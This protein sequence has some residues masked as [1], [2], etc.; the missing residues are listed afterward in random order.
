MRSCWY[1]QILF[2]I[3]VF[4]YGREYYEVLWSRELWRY[5]SGTV[6][7]L[8]PDILKQKSEI[9]CQKLIRDTS[10]IHDNIRHML[11]RCVNSE[12]NATHRS[13]KLNAARA[14]IV[15]LQFGYLPKQLPHE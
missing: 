3:V 10:I 6:R 11:L 7:K 13:S 4:K 14:R 9:K 5:D 1:K 2:H 12:S 15:T 8:R